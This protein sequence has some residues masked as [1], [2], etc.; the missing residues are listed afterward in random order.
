[1]L[2]CLQGEG[3]IYRLVDQIEIVKTTDRLRK[4]GYGEDIFNCRSY[5]RICNI[6]L[7]AENM[8]YCFV[9]ADLGNYPPCRLINRNEAFLIK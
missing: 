3:H 7:M 4:A 6:D 8:D 5:S 1:M 9:L 2:E